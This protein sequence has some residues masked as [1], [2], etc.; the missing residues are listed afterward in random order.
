MKI[1][2]TCILCALAVL[3]AAQSRADEVTFGN[4][5]IARVFSAG[6][7]RV[8]PAAMENR[9]ATERFDMMGAEFEILLMDGA[10][11]S[12]NDMKGKITRGPGGTAMTIEFVSDRLDVTVDYTVRGSEP[13]MWKR[14]KVCGAGQAPVAV[15][16]VSLE[17]SVFMGVERRGGMGQPL[18]LGDMFMGLESPVG[19]NVVENGEARLRHYPGWTLKAGEC[20]ESFPAVYGVAEKGQVGEAFGK[21]A[22]SIRHTV[23]S[24]LL[25]NSWYDVRS[26][27]MSVERF[28]EV[29]KG[30][31]DG[32]APY[33]TQ[34][35]YLVVDDGW[36]EP[37]SIWGIRKKTFPE[38]F[39]PLRK[40][41]ESGGTELGIWLPLTGYGLNISWG[42]KQGY[43]TSENDH[44][45]CMAG[46]KFN[47]ALR[48]RLKT[49]VADDGARYFKHDFNFISCMS[50]RT[51]YPQT[52]R[53]SFEA[54]VNAE[55]GLLDY[56]HSLNPDVY[57]NVTSYMWLSPWWLPHADTLWMGSSDYGYDYGAASLEPRDW[58][59]T[60]RDL[61]LYRR[62]VVEGALYPM[63]AVMTH[64][65][66]DGV[67]NRPGGEN[68]GFRTWADAAIMYFGRGVYMREL[69]LSPSLMNEKKWAFIARAAEWAKSMDP[70]FARTEW[71]GGD[72][73]LGQAYGYHHYGAGQDWFVLRNPGMD[74]Q[75][76][77]LSFR[78]GMI[79]QQVYPLMRIMKGGNKVALQGH[80]VVVLR[81]VRGKDLSRPAPVETD[82]APVEA[83]PNKTV[84]RVFPERGIEFA[85]TAA[86]DK[87]NVEGGAAHA[88]GLSISPASPMGLCSTVKDAY[89]CEAR[90]QIPEGS[91]AIFYAAFYTFDN[92]LM[93]E[94]EIDGAAVEG[95]TKGRGWRL[96]AK[97]LESG[98]GKVTVRIPVSS[99]RGAPFAASVYSFTMYLES[100]SGVEPAMLTVGHAAAV[101]TEGGVVLPP[102][103]EPEKKR[104]VAYLPGMMRET[105][106]FDSA[107]FAPEAPID[108]PVLKTAAAAKL[109]IRVFGSDRD[110]K[111][112]SLNGIP[113]GMLPENGFPYDFW[114]DA[115][116]DLPANVVRGLKLKN[117]FSVNNMGSDEFKF[118]DV[119]VSVQLA[120]GT[121]RTTNIEQRVQSSLADWQYSEGA[122]FSG[123]SKPV[124]L[125]F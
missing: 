73:R 44:H 92:Y 99:V 22:D 23:K 117:K 70:V 34:I 61:W 68:E 96:F 28:A 49:L 47:A 83:A 4:S 95:F 123:L 87:Y 64:G 110:M 31:K 120:D 51:S 93:N 100:E 78:D 35:D 9:L 14:L 109:R 94:V 77:A 27:R 42:D 105:L 15:D 124:S 71:V 17:A 24:N 103:R 72:P 101:G 40:A 56:I 81:A 84:Y 125:G 53:H 119:A 36:Q 46:P 7:G 1:I 65:M 118:S 104:V 80:E 52:E 113:A 10:V 90:V 37:D 89:V 86:V 29:Y 85:G 39:G 60:Y 88:A 5:A 33:G 8:E 19:Y 66:I 58:D 6:G 116:V 114:D 63:N 79:L 69:Y 21:Y 57:L 91:D 48:D 32:L 12:S 82:Y 122:V 25:Y 2:R 59:L 30:F 43:E 16:S 3:F 41:L 62:L 75:T 121:W 50:P 45:Y 18:F 26:D 102:L 11:I 98:A 13:L 108:A 97:K 115:V 67:L 54:N 20:G 74:R 112:M 55:I 106:D 107:E 76:L 111:L 38:G